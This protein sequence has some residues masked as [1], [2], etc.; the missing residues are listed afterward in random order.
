MMFRH[1]HSDLPD[2]PSGSD[3]LFGLPLR[4]DETVPPYDI[5]VVTETEFDRTV[6]RLAAEGKTVNVMKPIAFDWP[7]PPPTPTL[8][9]LVKHWRK[10]F[11]IFGKAS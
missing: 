9:A 3:R 1:A 7:A 6:R 8:R 5:K 11:K 2:E 10:K 4:I